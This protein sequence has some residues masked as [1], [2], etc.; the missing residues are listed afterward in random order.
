MSDIEKIREALS[1]G[2]R[3]GDL[4]LMKAVYQL[5]PEGPVIDNAE[6]PA[7]VPR[8]CSLCQKHYLVSERH[9]SSIP[10]ESLF[11]ICGACL[12]RIAEAPEDAPL[13]PADTDMARRMMEEARGDQLGSP[14][15]SE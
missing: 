7:V 15:D 1:F 14:E 8:N 10:A 3:T 11:N 13:S 6:G 5:K 2:S 9:A 4:E 12:D